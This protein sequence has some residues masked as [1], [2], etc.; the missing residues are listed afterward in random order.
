MHIGRCT[1]NSGLKFQVDSKSLMIHDTSHKNRKKYSL[2]NFT[3][4]EAFGCF[5]R[6]FVGCFFAPTTKLSNILV[7]ISSDSTKQEKNFQKDERREN[8]KS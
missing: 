8:R 2:I 4:F 3:F 5:P 6:T 1:L 7:M